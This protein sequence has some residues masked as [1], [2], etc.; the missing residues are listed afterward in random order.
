MFL[1]MEPCDNNSFK[2]VFNQ[3]MKDCN[4]CTKNTWNRVPDNNIFKDHMEPCVRNVFKEHME[5]CDGM[6]WDL[7]WVWCRHRSKVCSQYFQRC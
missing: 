7:L 1:H 6:G 2:Y 5:P 3:F 4:L